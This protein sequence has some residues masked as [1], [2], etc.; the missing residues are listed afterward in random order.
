VVQSAAVALRDAEWGERAAVVY[1]GSPEVADD[2]AG[3]VLANLGPAANPV[4]VIR[5]D[6]ILKLPNGKTDYRAITEYFESA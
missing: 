6:E 1:I 2:L 5:V 4:R 3:L